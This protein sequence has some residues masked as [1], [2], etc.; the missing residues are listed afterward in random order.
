VYPGVECTIVGVQA[1]IPG[2]QVPCHI[3][4]LWVKQERQLGRV[5]KREGAAVECWGVGTCGA[6]KAVRV[7]WDLC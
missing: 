5:G 1:H 7:E 2:A 6:L 4:A 3:V